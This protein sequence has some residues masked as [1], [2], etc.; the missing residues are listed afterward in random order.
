MNADWCV[1]RDGSFSVGFHTSVLALFPGPL[2]RGSFCTHPP[3]W[4]IHI[5]WNVNLW[6]SVADSISSLASELYWRL[7]KIEWSG[8]SNNI[9]ACYL[10]LPKAEY[11]YAQNPSKTLGVIS[12]KSRFAEKVF[13][14]IILCNNLSSKDIFKEQFIYFLNHFWRCLFPCFCAATD[15]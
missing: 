13:V 7:S 1:V 15:T 10:W 3:G 6:F 11:I 8:T 14:T 12:L 2:S 9:F 4:A 5:P